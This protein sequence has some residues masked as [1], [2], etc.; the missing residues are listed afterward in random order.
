MYLLLQ[1]RRIRVHMTVNI[2]GW[3]YLDQIQ[4]GLKLHCMALTLFEQDRSQPSNCSNWVQSSALF[5]VFFVFSS[6]TWIESWK[7]T[8]CQSPCWFYLSYRSP[9]TDFVRLDQDI[10]S[11]LA[12]K[13]Q[14]YTYET[15]DFWEQ[16]KTPGWSNFTRYPCLFFLVPRSFDHL[17]WIC[18]LLFRISIKCSALYLAQ[19]RIASPDLL[20][21]GD[22]TK[23]ATVVGDVC[24]HPSA[25]VHP[26]A[27]V[28]SC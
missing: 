9:P 1:H 23:N 14:L 6:K 2:C 7:D 13:R 22:G 24:I 25:K 16:I 21:K 19:F 18:I 27:K 12:G 3:G 26:T 17:I 20:A 28:I 11:P 8:L 5:L 10:L 4:R 15:M